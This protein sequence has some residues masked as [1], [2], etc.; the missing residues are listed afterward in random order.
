M[1]NLAT[2]RAV[3]GHRLRVHTPLIDITKGETVRR[4]L[5]LGVDYS[6]TRSCYDP[7]V[8]GEACGHCD[9]CLLRLRA[10]EENGIADPAPYQSTATPA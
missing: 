4:G 9:S 1:A 8:T 5:E 10:F 6:L 3:G 7:S 2:K